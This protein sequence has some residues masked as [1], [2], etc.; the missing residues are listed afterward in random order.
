MMRPRGDTKGGCSA[1]LTLGRPHA[2]ATDGGHEDSSRLSDCLAQSR[3]N[4]TA[5]R[6]HSEALVGRGPSLGVPLVCGLRVPQPP[7]QHPISTVVMW[8]LCHQGVCR[9]L[10]WVTNRPNSLAP[11]R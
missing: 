8:L 3:C 10:G 2:A 5:V 4:H 11:T 1:P 9:F 6:C 7:P